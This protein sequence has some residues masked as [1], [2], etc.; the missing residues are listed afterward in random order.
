MRTLVSGSSGLIGG[1]LVPALAQAGHAVGRL[2]RP[3]GA[4]RPGDVAWDLATGEIDRAALAGVDAVV[5][6]AGETI[7]GRW[8]A[9]KKR[10]IVQ[11]R[12]AGTTLLAEALAGL[13]RR[14][15]VLVSASG[16][17]YYGDRGAEVLT[18]ESAAGRGFLAETCQAWEAAALPAAR[19]GIRVVRLRSGIVLSPA[20]GVLRVMLPPF[21]LGLGGPIGRGRAYW[22]WITLS[23]MVRVI[24][25]VIED[26]AVVGA[27]NT[28]TPNPVTN[29][30]FTGMLARVLHRPAWIPVPPLALRLVFGREAADEVMLSSTRLAPAR[31]LASGFQFGY[32]ELGPALQ[33]VVDK[34]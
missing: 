23:D 21:R 6:L 18:E 17:H 26:D 22:S 10:R 14:P 5:H 31:L 33:A 7:L 9:R 27:I 30:Q 11:S 4:V 28:A 24:H 15:R 13:D 19:A 2:V 1:S 20:G 8:T 32:P 34:A 29:A 25:H 16:A 12:V 3:G